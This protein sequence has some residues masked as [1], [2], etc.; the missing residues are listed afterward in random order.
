MYYI[1][2]SSGME[3]YM[4]SLL[5]LLLVFWQVLAYG[6]LVVRNINCPYAVVS[7]EAAIVLPPSSPDPMQDVRVLS[8]TR[9]VGHS[10]NY[11]VVENGKSVVVPVKGAVS[12][13][14]VTHHRSCGDGTQK[15]VVIQAVSGSIPTDCRC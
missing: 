2:D 15:P 12:L 3:S 5:I 8:E 13:I 11:A 14:G 10:T 1:L 7:Y 9:T 4:K 6:E